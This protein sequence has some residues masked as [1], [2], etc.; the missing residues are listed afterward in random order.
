MSPLAARLFLAGAI[1][2]LGF[3]A[4]AA[5]AR[6]QANPGEQIYHAITMDDLAE[7]FL[8]EGLRFS[9]AP[10]DGQGMVANVRLDV[11]DGIEWA[12]LGYDC[13]TASGCS[14]L[15]FRA[16]FNAHGARSG[17][18][19]RINKWNAD[20][21][22]TRAYLSP[23]NSAIMEMDVY[24]A[25]GETLKNIRQQITIWRQSVRRFSSTMSAPEQSP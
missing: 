23:G 3:G 24:L 16:V 12:A 19:E 4:P 5:P 11:S 9:R 22:F 17:L 15:Q 20:N 14:E 21:R 7:T 1:A 13:K 8:L 6:A 25:G 2:W 10:I 18:L